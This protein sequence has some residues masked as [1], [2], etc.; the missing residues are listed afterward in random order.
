MEYI[1]CSFLGHIILYVKTPYCGSEPHVSFRNI[2]EVIDC[3][4]EYL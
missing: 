3:E 2:P 1:E 4:I